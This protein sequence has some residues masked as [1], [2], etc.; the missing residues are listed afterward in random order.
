MGTLGGK[1]KNLGLV[2]NNA[3]EIDG[4]LFCACFLFFKATSA[5]TGAVS[6]EMVLIQ[7]Q[8]TRS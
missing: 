6:N 2:N 8:F 1:R 3:D 4:T 7:Q 5:R